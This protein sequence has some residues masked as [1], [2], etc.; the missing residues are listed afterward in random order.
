[1]RIAMFIKLGREFQCFEGE[2]EFQCLQWKDD[3]K[4]LMFVRIGP[5]FQ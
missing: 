1:M 3:I 2:P 5:E 4:I